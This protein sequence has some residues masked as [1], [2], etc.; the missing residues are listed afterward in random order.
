MEREKKEKE[1]RK[2]K[3]KG[4]MGKEKWRVDLREAH[5]INFLL[6]LELGKGLLIILDKKNQ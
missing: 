5:E 6:N 1:K 3:G 4:K 2:G